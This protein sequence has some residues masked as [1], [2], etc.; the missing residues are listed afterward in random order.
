MPVCGGSSSHL[1]GAIAAVP[2]H[3]VSAHN[4]L[5]LPV[6]PG[7]VQHPIINFFL[8]KWAEGCS[9]V[10]AYS[11]EGVM[12]YCVSQPSPEKQNQQ[13]TCVCVHMHM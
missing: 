10:C 13:S 9:V 11:P 8:L 12:T 3:E 4:P 5:V 7:A 1:P 2:G 6:C